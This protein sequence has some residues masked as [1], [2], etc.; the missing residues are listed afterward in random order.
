MPYPEDSPFKAGD[1]GTVVEAEEGASNCQVAF[2]NGTTMVVALRHLESSDGNNGGAKNANQRQSNTKP[3]GISEVDRLTQLL[4]VA[5]TESS[6]LSQQVEELRKQVAEE[7]ESGKR[8]SDENAEVKKKIAEAEVTLASFGGPKIELDEVRIGGLKA[9]WLEQNVGEYQALKKEKEKSENDLIDQINR[10]KA[11]LEAV[12]SPDPVIT[13]EVVET[14]PGPQSP[15]PP[16]MVGSPRPPNMVPQSPR[17]PNMLGPQG[18]PVASREGSAVPGQTPFGSMA[19]GSM[20]PQGPEAAKMGMPQSMMPPMNRPGMPGPG[21][22]RGPGMPGPGM[23]G[24]N[25]PGVQGPGVRPPMTARPPMVQQNGRP[26]APPMGAP[27][28]PMMNNSYV[29]QMVRPPM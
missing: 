23:P 14:V 17:P 5:N 8:L 12:T 16:N 25:M 18:R 4:A 20:R 6:E 15:P 28:Q 19:P 2:D 10:L 27:G 1:T 26:G 3:T 11:E 21:G 29:P 9:V 7:Q 13:T 24:P 22:V